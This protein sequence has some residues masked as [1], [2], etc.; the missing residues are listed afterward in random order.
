MLPKAFTSDLDAAAKRAV[1]S[2]QKRADIDDD[3]VFV[4]LYATGKSQ[5]GPARLEL[6][7]RQVVVPVCALE[8]I[9][10]VVHADHD[11]S[12]PLE[13]VVDAF[14]CP[15]RLAHA[16]GLGPARPTA[17]ILWETGGGDKKNG[18][19]YSAA[20]IGMTNLDFATVAPV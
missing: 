14:G 11:V 19:G 6:T 5:P 1:P 4:E 2:A 10:L 3:F 20:T 17:R 7:R 13:G 16:P 12:L 15:S 8:A 18:F 9:V